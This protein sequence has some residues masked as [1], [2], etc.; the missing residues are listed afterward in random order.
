LDSGDDEYQ[1]SGKIKAALRAIPWP[2]GFPLHDRL[3]MANQAL[4]AL[5][6]EERRKRAV[7]EFDDLIRRPGGLD[8]FDEFVRE[9]KGRK[10]ELRP[11]F[12]QQR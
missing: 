7:D 4:S 2:E 3:E 11:V 9:F 8:A 1:L 5:F 12:R 10:V 6:E